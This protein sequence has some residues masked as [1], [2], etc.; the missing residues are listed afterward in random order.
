MA[1]SNSRNSL[2]RTVWKE[3]DDITQPSWFTGARLATIYIGSRGQHVLP[4]GVSGVQP[5]RVAEIGIPRDHLLGGYFT[6]AGCPISELMVVFLN[7]SE[8]H[9][10]ST[11]FA[12][13]TFAQYLSLPDYSR[14][15]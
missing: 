2:K 10:L 13:V 6:A 1:K 4:K 15:Y 3:T 12:I 8:P 9:A 7:L 5:G 14:I 11:T